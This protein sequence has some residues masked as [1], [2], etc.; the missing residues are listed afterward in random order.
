MLETL[1]QPPLP[2]IEISMMSPSTLEQDLSRELEPLM[3]QAKLIEPLRVVFGELAE[4]LAAGQ[5]NAADVVRKLVC[6]GGSDNQ[7]SQRLPNDMY[8]WLQNL[9]YEIVNI[10]YVYPS[11][12]LLRDGVGDINRDLL[13]GL[14][15][16]ATQGRCAYELRPAV[17]KARKA[18]AAEETPTRPP[19]I[20]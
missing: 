16:L 7:A 4:L 11:K 14:R 19:K 13:N 5:L 2:I 18:K 8:D 6:Y 10:H 12:Q 9:A 1:E 3:Q 17:I 15:S 20:T